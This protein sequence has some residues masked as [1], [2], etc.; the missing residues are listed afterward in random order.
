MIKAF[1]QLGGCKKSL[2]FRWP[3]FMLGKC[4]FMCLLQMFVLLFVWIF[5]H[6]ISSKLNEPMNVYNLCL[7]Y[8]SSIYKSHLGVVPLLQVPFLMVQ[9]NLHKHH[10]QTC[11]SYA[12]FGFSQI[13][14]CHDIEGHGCINF[15]WIPQSSIQVF[16]EELS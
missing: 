12:T 14:T 15:K 8:S 1:L 3:I 16:T 4:L 10:L 5:I 9:N 13:F 2:R 11:S 7:D 6:W